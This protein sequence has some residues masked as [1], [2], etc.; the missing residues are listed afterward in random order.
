MNRRFGR[1]IPGTAICIS[2]LLAA[3]AIP[4]RQIHLDQ[5][6]ERLSGKTF[7]LSSNADFY[8]GTGYSRTLKQGTTWELYGRIGEGEV[9]RSPGQTLTVEG[10]NIHE[11]YPVVKDANLVGVYLPVEKT[12]TPVSKNVLLAINSMKGV[13]E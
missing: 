10:Y 8:I 1:G 12:F 3:C 6:L 4:V 2:I 5:P 7:T 11:A 9:C 13:Q